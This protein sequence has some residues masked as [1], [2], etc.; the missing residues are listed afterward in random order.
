[1]KILNFE[2][3]AKTNNLQELELK[4]IELNGVFKGADEQCDSYFNIREGRLKL[5]EGGIENA[6][7]YYRREDVQG[8]KQ[9]DVMLYRYAPDSGLKELL[10]DALGIKVIV[11]KQRKIYFI[12]NVKFHL[13]T[14]P[15]L[16]TFVEVEAIDATG[17]RGVETLKDQCNYYA[18]IFKIPASAYISESYSDLLLKQGRID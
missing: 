12:G 2:F 17:E 18:E 16:G 1:M 8:A 11:K 6:L 10:T 14:V 7:I 9:S 3:K 5:R 15:G 4:I 13:D